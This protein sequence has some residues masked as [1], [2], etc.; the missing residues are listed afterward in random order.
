MRL[1]SKSKLWARRPY[2]RLFGIGDHWWRD[3]SLKPV[4]EPT[5]LCAF[6]GCWQPRHRHWLEVGEWMLP[7]RERLTRMSRRAL[8][9]LREERR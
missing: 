4:T 7:R 2:T 3:S 9:R 5:D 6:T 1:P 8:A